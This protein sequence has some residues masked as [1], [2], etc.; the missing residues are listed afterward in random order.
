MLEFLITF[1]LAAPII[2]MS[3]TVHEFF[4]AWSA[5]K[6]GDATAKSMGRMTLNPISHIDPLGALTMVL[7]GFRFG[8]SKPVPINEYNFVKPVL[9]TALSASAGPAS[10]FVLAIIFGLLYRL[11]APLSPWIELFLFTAV[12]INLALGLFNLL[13]FPPLDGYRIVRVFIPE[14]LRYY[15][16]QLEKYAPIAIALLILP[17]FPTSTFFLGIVSSIL[18]FFLVLL[19]GS[20]F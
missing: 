19:T 5:F 18:N 6:L 14:R 20:S 7:S 16:E 17:F 13:P 1:L 11:L 12:T 4:H 8:W 10:N 15:W 2:I 3:L 9:G